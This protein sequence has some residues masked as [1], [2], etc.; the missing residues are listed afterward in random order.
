MA[1]PTYS[2]FITRFPEL[3]VHPTHVVEAAI[4]T[5]S[6]LCSE[7]VW[8]PSH[9]DGVSYYAAHLISQRVRQV[10]ASVN[11]KT[12]DPGG[13]GVMGTIYGQQ[14]EAIRLTLPLTGFVV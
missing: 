10:G 2:S 1:A 8:G 13:D 5:A 6:R 3:V 4:A 11:E 7:G 14:Y 12:A 9:E